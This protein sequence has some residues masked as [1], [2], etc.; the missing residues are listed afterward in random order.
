[1]F[2]PNLSKDCPAALDVTIIS[3]MQ[4]LTLE[5]ASI[6]PGHALHVTEKRKLAA[7][8]E[9]CRLEEVNFIPLVLDFLRG[10][11]QDLIDV[12]EASGHLQV[13]RHGSY[14]SE[15]IHHLAQKISI[16][17]RRGNATL[18]TARLH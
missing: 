5:H 2:Q 10:W 7:H 14:P 6:T 11:G 1:M 8:G 12:V 16:S 18:L 13:Q 17:L 4:L 3:P 15:A 9:E